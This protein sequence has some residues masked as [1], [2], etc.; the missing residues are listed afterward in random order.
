MESSSSHAQTQRETHADED[1]GNGTN[2]F[3]TYKNPDLSCPVTQ[4][5]PETR[6]NKSGKRQETRGASEW[7]G[8]L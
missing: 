2:Y 5:P 3:F 1:E 8:S 4:P 6:K 7:E